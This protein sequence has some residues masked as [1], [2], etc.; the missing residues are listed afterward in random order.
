MVY[1]YD[2][3]LSKLQSY[4]HNFKKAQ[5]NQILN[6][7]LKYSIQIFHKNTTQHVIGLFWRMQMSIKEARNLFQKLF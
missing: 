7:C 4:L 2:E 5:N 6:Q 3:D 1:L